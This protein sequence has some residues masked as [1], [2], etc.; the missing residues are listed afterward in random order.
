MSKK[1][2]PKAS[3]SSGFFF[4]CCLAEGWSWSPGVAVKRR[5][6]YSAGGLRDCVSLGEADALGWAGASRSC[7]ERRTSMS[8]EDFGEAAHAC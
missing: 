6:I 5:R 1:S 3:Q 7:R 2:K 4:R 8:F